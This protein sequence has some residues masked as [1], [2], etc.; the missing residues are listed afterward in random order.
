MGTNRSRRWARIGFP[1]LGDQSPSQTPAFMLA[2]QGAGPERGPE[3]SSQAD[4]TRLQG[5]PRHLFTTHRKFLGPYGF[6][7]VG[8]YRVL[9]YEL[10]K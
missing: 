8:S 4:H 6:P 10:I 3:G 5:R 2:V 1:P 9:T 7:T